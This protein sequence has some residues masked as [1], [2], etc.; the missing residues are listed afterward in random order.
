DGLGPR[1]ILGGSMAGASMPGPADLITCWGDGRLSARRANR[2]VLRAAL[3]PALDIGRID[4]LIALSQQSP[5]L[6]LGQILDQLDLT[7]EQ[8]AR[9]ESILT[10]GSTCQAL[11]IIS[12][13]GQSERYRLAIAPSGAAGPVVFEW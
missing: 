6:S 2:Q 3:S 4:R 9:A 1:E 7:R 10:E 13:D 12:T 8:R 11:W 5:R